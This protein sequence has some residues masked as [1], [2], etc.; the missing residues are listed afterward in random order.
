MLSKIQLIQTKFQFNVTVTSSPCHIT[1]D[2]GLLNQIN[3]TK[4]TPLHLN[5][6]NAILLGVEERGMKTGLLVGHVHFFISH[7][8]ISHLTLAIT[9]NM[10][11]IDDGKHTRWTFFVVLFDDAEEVA[12]Q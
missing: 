12:K 5:T 4:L 7:H 2:L 3:T 9:C 6:S 10:Q 11:R 8:F 1:I